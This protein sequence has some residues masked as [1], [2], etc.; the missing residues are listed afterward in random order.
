MNSLTSPQCSRCESTTYDS[1][2]WT[3]ERVTDG[4]REYWL[5]SQCLFNLAQVIARKNSYRFENWINKE[6]ETYNLV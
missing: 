6:L 5:C 2:K 4:Q 1:Y 3:I